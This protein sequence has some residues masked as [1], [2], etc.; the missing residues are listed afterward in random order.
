VQ[1]PKVARS[2]LT[3]AVAALVIGAVASARAADDT[4]H[5]VPNMFAPVS[6][7]AESIRQLSFLVMGISAGIFVVVSAILFWCVWRYRQKPGD[8]SEP[9][10]VYGSNPIEWAW[11]IVPILI[12]LVLFLATARTINEL[13]AS[14]VPADA[15]EV[16]VIGHQWWWEIR[17]PSLGVVTANEV[18]LPVSAAGTKRPTYLVLESADVIHSFWIPQLAGKTDLVP[19]RRNRMWVEPAET[20]TFLGQC[21]EYCGTQHAK[22]MLR[23]IV[24]TPQDFAAWAAAQKQ[25]AIT[26]TTVGA[27]RAVFQN[28]ACVNC[29]MLDGTIADGRFGPDLSHLMSR[30]TIGAGAATNTRENLRAW[31]DDPHQFKPGALMPAMK[32]DDTQLDQLTD[33]LLTLK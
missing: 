2:G 13:Q 30:T 21:A 16:T 5:A 31:V 15:F 28:T 10:Q 22:M 3:G 9:P 4:V 25:P 17:Y 26:D 29:H 20:G 18:H 7:P 1:R 32:L 19:N 27:G 33:Y 24:Q 14:E 8:E 12:V 23:V 11:T 6:A